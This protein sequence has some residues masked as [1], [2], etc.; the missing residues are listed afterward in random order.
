MSKTKKYNF[1]V[2]DNPTLQEF[3]DVLHLL[4]VT[5]VEYYKSPSETL[6]KI[7]DIPLKVYDDIFDIILTE[8]IKNKDKMTV[9]EYKECFV[10]CLTFFLI[11]R[12]QEYL[13]QK[14]SLMGIIKYTEWIKGLA[15]KNLQK[16]AYCVLFQT[17]NLQ[18]IAN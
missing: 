4:G 10:E 11:A 12:M 9:A 18:G 6:A 3:L 7:S 17:S 5:D 15:D 14:I 8:K 13:K 2:T 16:L 1:N